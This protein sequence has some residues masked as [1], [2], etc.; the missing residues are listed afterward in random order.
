MSS[1]FMADVVSPT[2]TIGTIN[3]THSTF[4]AIGRDQLNIYNAD[5]NSSGISANLSSQHQ[6]IIIVPGEIYGWLSAVVPSTN[7]NSALKIRL[8]DTGLWFINNTEFARWKLE[9]DTFLWV[10]GTRKLPMILKNSL[11]L[12]FLVSWQRQDRVEVNLHPIALPTSKLNRHFTAH[13]LSKI[14]LITA[15]PIRR[16]LMRTSFS[17]EGTAKRIPNLSKVSFG[18]SSSSSPSS[19]EVFLQS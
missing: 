13:L 15:S 2:T 8:D 1:E 11:S 17:T 4:S 6:F 16:L 9:A 12:F 18:L 14:Y 10:D 5:Q 7:Y 3:A 19:M